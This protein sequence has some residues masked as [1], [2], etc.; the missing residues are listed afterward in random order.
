VLGQGDGV[1]QAVS[2]GGIVNADGTR[3]AI[4]HIQALARYIKEQVDR[5]GSGLDAVFNRTILRVDDNQTVA[6]AAFFV[7]QFGDIFAH[8][9]DIGRALIDRQ[10]ALAGGV[11][12][13]VQ[14]LVGGDFKGVFQ[15][16]GVRI[17]A[18]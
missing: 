4:G 15:F 8:M 3:A 12:G 17:H 1:Q 13:E 10:H 18:E 16:Q 11:K 9:I 6:L 5:A 7:G 14:Q 2:I